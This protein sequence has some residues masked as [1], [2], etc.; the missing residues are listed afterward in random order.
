MELDVTCD[1]D[2]VEWSQRGAYL[3]RVIET[4]YICSG[5]RCS[6][7]VDELF[8]AIV[9]VV[10]EDAG[11]RGAGRAGCSQDLLMLL[12]SQVMISYRRL[13]NTHTHTTASG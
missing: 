9:E 4:D 11:K 8:S 12:Q 2:V 6:G 5:R 7:D 10:V 3:H 13:T 1:G